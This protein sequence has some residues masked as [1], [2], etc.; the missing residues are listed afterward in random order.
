MRLIDADILDYDGGEWDGIGFSSEYVTANNIEKAPTFDLAKHDEQIRADE[1]VKVIESVI[2]CIIPTLC[3]CDVYEKVIENC[4]W[5]LEQMKE[6]RNEED[7]KED[8]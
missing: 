1:I 4:K 3:E 7:T 8:S 2:K 5:R 6:V